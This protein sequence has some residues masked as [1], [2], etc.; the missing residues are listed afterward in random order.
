M[1]WGGQSGR[2]EGCER[3]SLGV[4]DGDVRV[5]DPRKALLGVHRRELVARGQCVYV[6]Y[7]SCGTDRAVLMTEDS[8]AEVK[9][10]KY[11]RVAEGGR[12]ADGVRFGGWGAGELR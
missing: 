8:T 2:W 10:Q 9:T 3:Q 5:Q 12:A 11:G 1:R 6:G 4:L 7:Q